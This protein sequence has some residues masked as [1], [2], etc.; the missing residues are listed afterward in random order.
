MRIS[1]KPIN[2]KFNDYLSKGYE[3]LK[4]NFGNIFLAVIFCIIMA[5]IPFCAMLGMGNLYTYLRKL[6]KGENVG[7]GEIF[8]FDNFTPYFILQLIIIGGILVLYIPLAIIMF[9]TQQ[10][11]EPSALGSVLLFPYLAIMY[12]IIFAVVLKGFYMPALISL[13]GVKDVKTAWNMSKVMTKGNIWNILLFSIVVGFLSQLGI[14]ACGIGILLTMP[15]SYT[16]NY[17]AF[18]DAMQQIEHDE[19]QEIGLKNEY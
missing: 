11:G 2:F 3:F 18:E 14:I 19:I 9:A 1:V 13:G 10:N 8:N 4:A 12:I 6:R 15:Y 5:I 7:A 16:A 17:F